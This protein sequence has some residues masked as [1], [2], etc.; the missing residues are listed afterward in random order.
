MAIG[1]GIEKVISNRYDS[2]SFILF[3]YKFRTFLFRTEE[4][5]LFYLC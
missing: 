3:F 2:V 5:R 4:E 1:I